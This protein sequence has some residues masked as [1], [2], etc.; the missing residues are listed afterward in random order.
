MA[1]K[2]TN[3]VIEFPTE[4]RVP[5]GWKAF[6]VGVDGKPTI[7][8]F[9]G[10][11][12]N[13]NR[14]WL[15][16]TAAID[17]RERKKVEVS[18]SKSGE[19]LGVIDM[20][21]AHPFQPFQIELSKKQINKAVKQGLALKMV[22]GTKDAWF[23][24]PEGTSD[25][26]LG[27]RPQL[28]IDG[29]FE[30]EES[31]MQN[32]YSMNS[33]SPF[34]WMGGCVQ[35][36]LYEMA[37]NGNQQ[38]EK[39]LKMHLNC[40]LDDQKGVVFEDPHTRPIDGRFN[41]IEDFLPFSGI[42]KYHPEHK[43]INMMLEFCSNHEDENGLI[44]HHHIT[45]E[46]CYT[47]AYPLA[48][49]AV[50]RNDDQLARKA[51]KQLI[52]RS[53]YLTDD[54]AIYQRSTHEGEKGYANWGRGTVWYLIG[55]AKTLAVLEK[56]GFRDLPEVE[57]IKKKFLIEVE[58]ISK[59]QNPKGM[60]YSF[61]DQPETEIDTTATSGIAASF[62]WGNKLG[63]LDN[64]Y[65]MKAEMAYQ[66]LKSYITPDGF[67]TNASQINRGGVELQA[68]EY[69]VITQFALGLMAQ[70]KLVLSSH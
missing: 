58:K 30:W 12:I 44:A 22:E 64:S 8:Y 35:D 46:G 62:A 37:L 56:S 38:A 50:I 55:M 10:D 65:R 51:L 49:I 1:A 67:L 9:E 13:G 70:L 11:F 16:I 18:L 32:M 14:G 43:S 52:L 66:A 19:K 34:G 39:T 23:F 63:Y 24:T 60:W 21:F 2:V 15:R 68:S 47:L 3:P 17:F 20:W 45:T 25:D 31:V 28:L 54:F 40:Y 53:N 6:P 7:L 69:R 48:C 42:A 41:S 36:A 27:L 26:A 29:G 59:Y 5:L 57:T 33:F 4:K 61:L